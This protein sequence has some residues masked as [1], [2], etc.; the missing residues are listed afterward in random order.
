ML[1]VSYS[2]IKSWRFCKQAHFYKYVEEIEP[3]RKSKPL[4]VGSI[5]HQ[6]DETK[7]TGGNWRDILDQLKKEYKKMF[8]EEKEFYG[9]LPAEIENIMI[10]YDEEYG[11]NE[12]FNYYTIEETLP[13]IPL[14]SKTSLKIK[15]DKIIEDGGLNFL[16]ETKTGR[17][18]PEES[19][20]LWDLQTAI[21]VWGA[22]QIGYKMN[23]IFWNYIRTKPPT[24][25]EVLKNGELSQRKNIDTNHRTYLKAI[26]DHKLNPADYKE[27]LDLL[28]ENGSIFFRRM[29]LPIAEKTL[30]QIAD[31]AKKSS[32]EIYYMQDY[33]IREISA[34][35]CQRCFYSSLCYAELRGIDS[36]F[37][38]KAEYKKQEKK[39]K[40]EDVINEEED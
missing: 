14:T 23:G 2:R 30:D 22:R 15:P 25:P 1:S 26:K 37:I 13:D 17:K 7:F 24:I 16:W 21:Y 19:T 38:R 20:R 3:K 12:K 39:I 11:K 27:I 34:F 36:E 33:P 40:E 35:S 10:G 9:D 32:L 18:I 4:K 29:K 28:K 6:M 5:I 8:E 31:D